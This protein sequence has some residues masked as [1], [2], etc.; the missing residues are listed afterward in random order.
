M[1]EVV[2]DLVVLDV[3][4]L[5]GVAFAREEQ[6]ALVVA[7]WDCRSAGRRSVW[8]T[9]VHATW[10]EAFRVSVVRRVVRLGGG[11]RCG[12]FGVLFGGQR[13]NIGI[14]M[15][16]KLTRRDGENREAFVEEEWGKDD[17][18]CVCSGYCTR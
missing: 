7:A 8:R 10:L 11:W 3:E 2:L 16:R 17:I 14:M 5:C 9:A 6:R 12:L 15:S 1:V 13:C 4:A 18:A